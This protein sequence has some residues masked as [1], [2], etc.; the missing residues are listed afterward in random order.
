MRRLNA[1]EYRRES[2][3]PYPSFYLD[4][5]VDRRKLERVSKALGALPGW[6]KWRFFTTPKGSLAGLTPLDALKNGKY[7]EVL[8]AAAGFAER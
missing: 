6:E 5:R 2:A 3:R 4:S 7:A 1:Q 8:T